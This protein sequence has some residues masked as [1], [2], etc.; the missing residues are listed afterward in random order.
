LHILCVRGPIFILRDPLKC[1]GCRLCEVACSLKKEGAV[2]P[3]ASRIRVYELFP[4]VDVP[5]TCA[6]CR[7]YPC[8]KA[9]QFGALRVDDVTG[10]VLVDAEKCTSCG[11]CVRACPGKVMR[12]HP[13]TGKAMV[14][15][16][17]GGDPECVRACREAGFNA[18]TVIPYDRVSY[19][20]YSVVPDE[21]HRRLY[22]TLFGG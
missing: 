8:V 17:C 10:A 5:H 6:Q 13:G 19:N 7:D 3:E 4:G 12:L 18:L 9:C 11:S 1:T 15:D 21:V 16:L 2:W 22:E 20:V 14:C